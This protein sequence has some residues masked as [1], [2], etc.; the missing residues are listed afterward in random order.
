MKKKADLKEWFLLSRF[1]KA[2]QR[3]TKKII[4]PGFDR[5]PLYNVIVFFIKGLVD[6]E[7]TTRASS[8]AFKFF[9]AMFPAII[10]LFTLIPYIPIENFQ[11][12]L[13][14]QLHDAVPENFYLLI[15]STITDIVSRQQGGLLSLGFILA[16]Y[17]ASNGFLGVIV[18][19]NSTSHSIETRKIIQQYF[20][21]IVLVIIISVLIFA[22]TALILLGTSVLNFLVTRDILNGDFVIFVLKFGKWIVI[23]LMI[24][25][26][27]SFMYYLAPAKKQ[28]FRFISAGSTL[29]TIL[30]IATTLGFN[31]Y[32]NN[33]SK[34]NTLYGSIGTIIVIMMW[35]YLN[36]IALLVG[37]ELN[38]SIFSAKKSLTA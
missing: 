17:F 20:I 33:F 28:R 37:F 38:A 23:L 3:V 12:T 1:F 13:L 31:F 4:L 2:F 26:S 21:S 19:F 36:S 14:S 30:F 8:I 9:M 25:F 6:G 27:I 22:S 10:F 15:S 34:Y 24:F 32:V 29:A 18:A 7:I 5:M 16:L 11:T 35:L